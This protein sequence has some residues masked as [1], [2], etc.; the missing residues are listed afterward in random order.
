MSA[1]LAIDGMFLEKIPQEGKAFFFF[2]AIPFYT[3]K[4][5]AA[6]NTLGFLV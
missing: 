3:G 5:I 1:A 6:G 4:D 2:P